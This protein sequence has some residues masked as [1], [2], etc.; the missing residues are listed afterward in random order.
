MQ[1]TRANFIPTCYRIRRKESMPSFS[2]R[3]SPRT[4]RDH[5][6]AVAAASPRMPQPFGP[7]SPIPGAA[8]VMDLESAAWPQGN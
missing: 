6:L 4:V 5:T 2:L 8:Q 1:E 3:L 7:S